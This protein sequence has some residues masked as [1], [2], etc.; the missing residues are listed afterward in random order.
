MNGPPWS[1]TRYA[2]GGWFTVNCSTVEPETQFESFWTELS[3]LLSHLDLA[4]L[5]AINAMIAK[6]GI[7]ELNP[8]LR[9]ENPLS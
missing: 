1:R 4:E 5:N 7:G 3:K 8:C 9:N 6:Q 2:E